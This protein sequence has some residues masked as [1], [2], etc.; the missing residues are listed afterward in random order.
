MP[1]M[2]PLPTYLTC[3]EIAA[4]LR[5]EPSTAYR[6]ARDGI[7]Q[8][9]RVGGIVRVPVAELERIAGKATPSEETT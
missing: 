1:T 7:V 8:S 2:Q 6:W 5:I 4:A 3:P 9:V